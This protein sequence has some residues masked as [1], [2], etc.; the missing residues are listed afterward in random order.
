MDWR[1]SAKNIWRAGRWRQW[2]PDSNSPLECQGIFDRCCWYCNGKSVFWTSPAKENSFAHHTV[3]HHKIHSLI[4]IPAVQF[5]V[6]S[7]STSR[8][9][10]NHNLELNY[11][12]MNTHWSLKLKV[13]QTLIIRPN[14]HSFSDHQHTQSQ[15]YKRLER[16]KQDTL[17]HEHVNELKFRKQQKNRQYRK[18]IKRGQTFM[19]TFGGLKG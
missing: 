16:I 18:S 3:V 12:F 17:I 10:T 13:Q 11:E 1:Q 9:N 5:P 2:E 19:P 8:I 14:L 6:L 7:N 15:H 4:K